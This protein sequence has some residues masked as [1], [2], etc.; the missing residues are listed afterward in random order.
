MVKQSL[1]NHHLGLAGLNNYMMYGGSRGVYTHTVA[2]ERDA[3]CAVCSA[4]LLLE[5]DPDAPLSDLLQRLAAE[6]GL[7]DRLAAPSVSYG[8]GAAGEE[9]GRGRRVPT[10]RAWGG[11][12]ETGG[13]GARKL[14]VGCCSGEGGCT[15]S[16]A[17]RRMRCSC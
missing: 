2:Y 7:G 9:A 17:A 12:E 14:D 5:V 16:L 13:G 3:G 6:P 1:P 10:W 4:G 15:G 11:G 8:S